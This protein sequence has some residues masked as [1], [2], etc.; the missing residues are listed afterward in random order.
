[1][2]LGGNDPLDGISIYDGGSYWHF[3]TYGFSE[4]YDKEEETPRLWLWDGVH[5]Q[6]EQKPALRMW[7][8][9]K[10]AFAVFAGAGTDKRKGKLWPLN[11]FTG[12][13]QALTPGKARTSRAFNGAGRR[14]AKF[15]LNG[16]VR[17]VQLVGATDA[18]CSFCFKQLNAA[19]V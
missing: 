10:S 7:T 18:S 9:S 6:A 3:V 19:V 17:F 14:P 4:P 8:Q 11:I 16:W 2:A 13:A 1:M 12:Q 5:M 15:A